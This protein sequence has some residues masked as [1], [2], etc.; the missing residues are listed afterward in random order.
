MRCCVL[1]AAAEA[2]LRAPRPA[3]APSVVFGRSASSD[4]H[5]DPRARDARLVPKRT[6]LTPCLV[7]QS[8][9]NR[10]GTP[11]AHGPRARAR[12]LVCSRPPRRTCARPRR[13]LLPCCAASCSSCQCQGSPATRSRTRR[14]TAA[15]QRATHVDWLRTACSCTDARARAR[16]EPLVHAIER[17]A[18]PRKPLV[19]TAPL[20]YRVRHGTAT[21]PWPLPR[22]HSKSTARP[23]RRCTPLYADAPATQTRP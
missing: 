19:A 16:C 11:R 23:G 21:A 14:D 18:R 1:C 6:P 17:L 8:R 15:V 22:A 7:A 13:S 10:L 4:L 12:L 3:R 2:V 9:L 20:R 5:S